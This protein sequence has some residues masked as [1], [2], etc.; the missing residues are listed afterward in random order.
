MMIDLCGI[1]LGFTLALVAMLPEA[2]RSCR[3]SVEQ[4]IVCMI[5]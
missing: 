1:K 3:S 2:R 4:L 5:Q